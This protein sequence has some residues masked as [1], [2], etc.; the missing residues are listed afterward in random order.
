LPHLKNL[1]EIIPH[2]R[3]NKKKKGGE[4]MR[5]EL[6]MKVRKAISKTIAERYRNSSKKEKTK[7]LDEFTKITGYNRSYAI[8][9]LNRIGKK[10]VVWTKNKRLVF[11]GENI[12]VK[13]RKRPIIYDDKVV[14]WLKNIWV[15][16]D[17]PCGKRLSPYM[18][19]IINRLDKNGMKIEEDIK[20]KLKG[21]SAATID[22]KLRYYKKQL[23]LKRRSKTKPGS[24]LKSQIQVRTFSDW[25]EKMPGFIEV[26]LVDHSGGI[27]RGIFAQSLDATDVFTGW[28]ETIC[29]E[30][31]SQVKVFEGLIKIIKQFPFQILGIDSDNGSEFINHH[32]LKFCEENK[33]T[34]TKSRPYKKNDSCY[35]EQ[36]NWSVV[37]KAVGYW[38]YETKQEVETINQI[39]RYLRLYTNFFQVQM[40][41]IEKIRIG[42]KIRK[43]Y[44]RPKTPYQRVMECENIDEKTKK[45]L[46]EIYES[47]NPVEIKKKLIELEDKLFEMVRRK[48]LKEKGE[49]IEKEEIFA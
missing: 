23:E 47:L 9:L 12:R 36:K 37:R 18:E 7:I 10:V 17:Y 21:M 2:L 15:L 28:T 33:I 27:E 19:E 1:I 48:R 43:K 46:K 24:L 8:Y 42:S 38:R 22:R 25:D 16:L 3:E 41:L 11:I 35:V 45:K 34:F 49:K 29:V 40:K 44:D 6:D 5:K 14:N 39:Y 30:N 31:K 32:L 20:D 26:D 13:K 4:K